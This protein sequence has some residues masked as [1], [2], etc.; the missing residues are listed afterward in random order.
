MCDV[1]TVPGHCPHT[2]IQAAHDAANVGDT[3][4]L[5]GG[6]YTE[7]VTISKS[8]TLASRKGDKVVLQGTGPGSVVT[9][10]PG[11]KTTRHDL[12]PQET[13]SG[14]VVT[15]QPGV[16]TTITNVWISGG[17]GTLIDGTLSGGGI[18]NYG[19]LTLNG[20]TVGNGN[21]AARGGGIYNA[22]NVT[23]AILGNGTFVARNTASSDGG[24]IYNDRGA[25]LTI[26]NAIVG[27]NTATGNGGGIF[28]T[29][30]LATVT[31][32][33]NAQ[34]EENNAAQG[35]GIYSD[36]GIDSPGTTIV[37]I[38]DSSVT[39]NQARATRGSY[40]GHGVAP[41]AR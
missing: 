23:L 20:G 39:Q 8:L 28:N 4:T 34:I 16:T 5:C 3:L 22:T 41:A 35:A 29:G 17:T 40:G 10:H 36:I 7:N 6:T 14:S 38:I 18:V 31:I 32:Q 21:T 12:A 27:K 1:C 13:G 9:V 37:T 15:I 19:T 2:S 24:G 30:L 26:D 25:T 11:S 33:N